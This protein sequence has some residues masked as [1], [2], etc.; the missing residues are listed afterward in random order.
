V[1]A[2]AAVVTTVEEAALV[3]IWLAPRF[4][5]LALNTRSRLVTEALRALVAMRLVQ[6]EKTRLRWG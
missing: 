3:D 6:M 5:L 4:C 2:A 1:V